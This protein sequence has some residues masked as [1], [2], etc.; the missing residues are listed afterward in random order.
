MRL[1]L[2]LLIVTTGLLLPGCGQK[3]AGP[4]DGT[5][6]SSGNPVTAPVD[7]LGAVAKAK[8][9]AD[10]TVSTAGLN[11]AIQLYHAQEGQLP[12][13]LND[14]VTK[15]YISS[16]PPPPAGMKYEYNPKTGSLKI[17]PQ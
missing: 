16:V 17:V 8:K 6:A 2:S 3:G 12:K 4:T 9:V 15:Q 1:A 5:N 10:K 13:T 14:L 11:Q 7:Y